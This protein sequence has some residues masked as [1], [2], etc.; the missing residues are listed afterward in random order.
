MCR[1]A[2]AFRRARHIKS[3]LEERGPA[4]MEVGGQVGEDRPIRVKAVSAA[5]KR[6][7]RL[8]VPHVAV[9]AR[10]VVTGDVGRVADD[11]RGQI[12]GNACR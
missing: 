11:D 4:G 3:N 5:G 7:A 6:K 2:S 9:E 12:S 10:Y 1:A 8:I